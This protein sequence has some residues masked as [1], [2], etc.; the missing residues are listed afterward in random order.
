[1]AQ[2][3]DRSGRSVH[4]PNRDIWLKLPRQTGKRTTAKDDRV[5]AAPR[6]DIPA[7]LP[8][9]RFQ[10][11]LDFARI[12]PRA[13]RQDM[14]CIEMAKKP[15]MADDGLQRGCDRRAGLSVRART[16]SMPVSP[17]EARM[18]PSAFPSCRATAASTPSSARSASSRVTI[19]SGHAGRRVGVHDQQAHG[20]TAARMAATATAPGTR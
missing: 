12:G 10:F 14:D 15:V 4:E 13:I 17:K 9:G 18:I 6:R 11:G 19:R 2:A 5:N 7:Q 3:R 8:Q 20:V 1:M 16:A